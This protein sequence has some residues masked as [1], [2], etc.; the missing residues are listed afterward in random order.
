[1]K[2]SFFVL[3]FLKSIDIFSQPNN[4]FYGY[5][6]DAATRQGLIGV[7][8][9]IRV[10]PTD[11]VSTDE[12]GMFIINNVDKKAPDY[13]F[14][15]ERADYKPTQDYT[16]I[17]AVKQDKKDKYFCGYFYMGVKIRQDCLFLLIIKQVANQM[18][19]IPIY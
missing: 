10:P 15:L 16:R 9:K 17:P 13:D 12:D 3:F 4:Q 19:Q 14:Y 5:V 18:K 1:M 11:P 7:S 8:V 6:I 2:K